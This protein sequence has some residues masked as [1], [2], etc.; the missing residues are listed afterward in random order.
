MVECDMPKNI[1]KYKHKFIGN[2]TVRELLGFAIGSALVIFGY[3]KLFAGIG[4]GDYTNSFRIGLSAM[5]GVPFFVI[6]YVQIYDLPF[7]KGAWIVLYDNFIRPLNRYYEASPQEF[8]DLAK[9]PGSTT[10]TQTEKKK[11]SKPKL[12][13]SKTYKPIR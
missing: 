12:K 6:G 9:E 4:G 1:L 5:L 11:T 7:E 8:F 3:F 10:V 13:S 2:F